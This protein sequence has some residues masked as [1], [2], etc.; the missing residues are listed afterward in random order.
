MDNNSTHYSL[1]NCIS[2]LTNVSTPLQVVAQEVLNE[3]ILI[4]IK[5]TYPM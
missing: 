5:S 1:H 4:S 2:S 3:N